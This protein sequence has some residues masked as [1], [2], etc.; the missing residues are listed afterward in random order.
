MTNHIHL[1]ISR[2][3]EIPCED[4]IRDFKKYTCN[5]IIEAIKENNKDGRKKLMLDIFSKHGKLNSNN[6]NYQFWIQDNHPIEL[7]NNKIIDQK[8]EYLHNNPVVAGFVNEPEHYL[9]S[10]AMDY[11]EKKGLINVEFLF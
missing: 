6:T 1:I 8:L 11:A 4:I 10:S 7:F 2:N 9:Y 3:K 5:K